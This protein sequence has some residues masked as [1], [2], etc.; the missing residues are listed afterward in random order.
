MNN[1]QPTNQF[2]MS[3]PAQP[4][5]ATNN[6]IANDQ[7]INPF[8]IGEPVVGFR[9]NGAFVPVDY[10]VP[11]LEDIIFMPEKGFII[12]PISTA[13]GMDPA[14]IMELPINA[15]Y[16]NTKR[17]Y[18]NMRDHIAQ[19]LN[20]FEKFYDADH[21][22]WAIFINIK[23]RMDTQTEYYTK[24][25]FFHDLQS[26]ILN[27]GCTI[28]QKV[29]QMN[30]ENYSLTLAYRNNRNPVLQYTEN[31]AKVMMRASVLMNIVIPLITHFMYVKKIENTQAFILEV[32]DFILT[33]LCDGVDIISK[34]YETAT[35][36]IGKNANDHAGLWEMQN[37]RGISPVTHSINCVENIIVSIMPKYNYN[38]NIIHFNYK[39]IIN[40]TKFQVTDISYEYTFVTLS[41]SKRDEDNNSEFDKYESY[42]TKDS[43]AKFL[44]NNAN[45]RLVMQSLERMYGPFDPDEIAFV[46]YELSKGDTCVL[47]EETGELRIVPDGRSSVRETQ[48]H[49]IF[50]LFCK[51][52][53][54]PISLR[55]INRVDYIKLIIIAKRLLL[56]HGMITL[57]Y[58]ISGRFEVS[59]VKGINMKEKAKIESHKLYDDIRR[60][61][62]DKEE[63]MTQVMTLI[64][65]ILA[66]RFT[67]IDYYH[68]EL[69]GQ[70]IPIVSDN[71]IDEILM[72][73]LMI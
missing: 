52:F 35:T 41:S 59:K 62:N 13:M 32:F 60:K 22:L 18:N 36:N 44:T 68:P 38:Q 15:F 50:L 73:I 72:F 57:P 67:I 65:Q 39:S 10:W 19:Y 51:Y 17:C 29:N 48:K 70:E 37:I 42:Q 33:N 31:H 61:Y 24:E 69:N 25:W 34:L 20:Y 6:N 12:V 26:M 23:L 9:T 30:E 64:G 43:E 3:N 40:N 63:S 27:P 58:I 21:E 71:I 46:N 55:E 1:T 8:V 16:L 7:P 2:Y 5:F 53:Q 56:Q 49:L 4:D 14:L 45:Y 66:S 54:D 47:D 11:A 28:F